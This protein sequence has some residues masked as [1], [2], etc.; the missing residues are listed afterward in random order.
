MKLLHAQKDKEI[1]ALRAE[2][3]ENEM[4]IKCL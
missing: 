1:E 2:L 4:K 3:E